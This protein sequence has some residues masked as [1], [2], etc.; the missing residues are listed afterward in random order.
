MKLGRFPAVNE[1]KFHSF[2]FFNHATTS[3]GHTRQVKHFSSEEDS[4]GNKELP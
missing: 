3:Q 2:F 4:P 1:L